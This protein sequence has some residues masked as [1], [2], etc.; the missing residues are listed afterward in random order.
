MDTQSKFINSA[1]CTSCQF[2]EDF[3]NYWTAVMYFRAK[4]GTVKRLQQ[5]ANTGFE[6]AKGGMTIYYMQDGLMDFQQKSKVTSFPPVGP[7]VNEVP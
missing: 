3:S 7:S 2:A 5:R 1:T 6:G 4:N